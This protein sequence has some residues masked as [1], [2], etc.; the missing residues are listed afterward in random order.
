[1]NNSVIFSHKSDEW[2]TPKSFFKEIDKEFHFNLDAAANENNHKCEKYF[3][4]Q[5]DGL[6][7]NRG[8]TEYFAI[9]LIVKLINGLKRHLGRQEMIIRLLFY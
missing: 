7:Q 3:T 2:S 5:Q 8:G 4:M 6:T 1:M 9:R